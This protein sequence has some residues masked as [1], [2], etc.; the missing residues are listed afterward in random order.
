MNHSEVPIRT[1]RRRPYAPFGG[2]HSHIRTILRLIRT[3]RFGGAHLHN[4]EALIR[5]N[6]RCSFAPFG[7]AH[8][9]HSEAPIRTIRIRAFGGMM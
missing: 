2:A 5:T 4:S 7:G 1:T 3:I 9:H 6:L 8:S